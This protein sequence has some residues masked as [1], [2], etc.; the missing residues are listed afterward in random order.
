MPDTPGRAEAARGTYEPYRSTLLSPE[1]VRE[2][3]RLR[4]WRAGADALVCWLCIAAAW[5]AVALWP[6]WWI[7]LSAIPV[8][9]TRYYALF[10]IGHD[11]LHR[12]LMPR[13]SANDL[14]TDLALY[15][16]IGAIT[17]INRMNHIDHHDFLASALDPDRHRHG[18]FN[19]ADRWAL[20]RYLTGL[21]SIIQSMKNV[22]GS[23]TT[24]AR[25]AAP[26]TED[27]AYHARD[28]SILVGWQ[29]LL[30]GGLT[31]GIGWWAYPVLWLAPVFL[32]AVLGDNL[33]S[34]LE[35]SHPEPDEAADRH[36]LITFL[37][38]PAERLLLGPMNMNYHTVHHLWTSIPYYNLPDAD[39]EI[40]GKAAAEGLAWRGSYLAYLWRYL[41]ALP[42]EDCRRS[43]PAR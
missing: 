21:A 15:G 29:A 31:W 40:R 23:G 17:H 6:T 2:L 39:R 30:L 41:R 11:G 27:T 8:V 36:R 18:C 34:F 25:R 28:V 13:R 9:G 42:L 26:P 37:S 7:V 3:S 19:K 10:I 22:F 43:R 24:R 5:G 14:F 16:P 20:F 33:R 1:R 38:S 32:F 4:P 35:H 12:R